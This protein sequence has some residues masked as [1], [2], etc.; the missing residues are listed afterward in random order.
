MRLHTA[1]RSASEA[2]HDITFVY[3][4]QLSLQ[5]GGISDA[6]RKISVMAGSNLDTERGRD[7]DEPT[8]MRRNEPTHLSDHPSHFLGAHHVGS[9]PMR[10]SHTSVPTLCFISTPSNETDICGHRTVKAPHPVRSAKLSTVSPSQ[11]CGGGPRGNPGCCS[12][13]LLS[14]FCPSGCHQWPHPPAS[15]SHSRAQESG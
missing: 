10:A 14:Y 13:L 9:H 15:K 1:G 11:Y 4:T 6:Q 3:C 5:R 7:P 8:T 2:A 12:F